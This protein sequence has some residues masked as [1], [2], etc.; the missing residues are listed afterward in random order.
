MT[1]SGGTLAGRRARDLKSSLPREVVWRNRRHAPFRR[2]ESL[3]PKI[4]PNKAPGKQGEAG[5][6]NCS[7]ISKNG[8]GTPR[9][10]I[11]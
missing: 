8:V 4:D 10:I 11:P 1:G 7:D 9:A 6:P 2:L 3:L 5:N